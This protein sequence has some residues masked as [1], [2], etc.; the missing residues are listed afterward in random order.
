MQFPTDIPDILRRLLIQY[1]NVFSILVGL[2]LSRHCDH[3]IPLQA[4][5]PPIK[6]KPYCYPHSHK[7][8]I[9]VMVSQMLT[10]GLIAPSNNPFSS[11]V[12]LVK[13]KDGLWRFC[14]DYRALNAITIN[15]AFPIP[16]VN[17]LLDE[18]HGATIFSKLDLRSS[19]YQ[20]LLHHEDKHK[21]AF[22]THHGHF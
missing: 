21:T 20:V 22:R 5:A 11:P 19:Y 18:L 2:P 4:G 14:T 15:N 17:E 13:K 3:K 1:H 9:E 6:V 10:E 7:S 8:E 12:L 16:T